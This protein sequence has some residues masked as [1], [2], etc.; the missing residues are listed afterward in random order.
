[1]TVSTGT[2]NHLVD[3]NF[4]CAMGTPGG[5]KN[6]ITQRFSRHLNI[7]S[8][9][10]M[11]DTSKKTIFS[12]ILGSCMGKPRL[13]VFLNLKSCFG[14]RSPAAGEEYLWVLIE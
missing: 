10:D 1:M 2:F 12:T 4:A 8:F 13:S 5:I 3:I 7:L 11:E 14:G 6:T 9:I